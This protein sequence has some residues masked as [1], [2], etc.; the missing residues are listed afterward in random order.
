MVKVAMEKRDRSTENSEEQQCQRVE[1]LPIGFTFVT[2]LI[3]S[4]KF[5]ID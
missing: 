5:S 4:I 2:F 3:S 1:V